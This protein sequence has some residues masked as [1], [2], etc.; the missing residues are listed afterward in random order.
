MKVAVSCQMVVMAPSP[1]S[2]SESKQSASASAFYNYRFQRHTRVASPSN[3]PKKCLLVSRL[4]F[5]LVPGSE[6]TKS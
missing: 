2:P 1:L 3:K 5:C 4:A 6:D